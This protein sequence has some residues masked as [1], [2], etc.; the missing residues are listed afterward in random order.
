MIITSK[1]AMNALQFD[2]RKLY[3]MNYDTEFDNSKEVRV[4][5]HNRKVTG[6][7]QYHWYEVEYFNKFTDKQLILI[8]N[9]IIDYVE[10]ELVNLVCDK[11]GV[12]SLTVDILV[13]EDL[14]LKLVELNSFGYWLAAGSCLFSWIEDRDKL[15]GKDNK[16]YFK[17]LV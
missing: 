10:K 2:D 1:R 9:N 16:V 15:Y 6:I 12:D 11:I 5:V 8:C 4:F 17:I 14:S 3:F 13:R 7:S